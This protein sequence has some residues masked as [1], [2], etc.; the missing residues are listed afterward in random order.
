MKIPITI[1]AITI[2]NPII[3][4][5]VNTC[6][7]YPGNSLMNLEI[8]ICSKSS[9]KLLILPLTTIAL[10]RAFSLVSSFSKRISW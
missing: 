6:A 1:A 10:I 3:N 2:K 5:K 4:P 9:G 7:L 8:L